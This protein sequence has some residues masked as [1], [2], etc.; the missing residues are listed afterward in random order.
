MAASDRA[1]EPGVHRYFIASMFDELPVGPPPEL[2][3]ADFE[4]ARSAPDLVER[5]RDEDAPEASE[6]WN[7][8]APVP[9]GFRFVSFRRISA[10]RDLPSA[11]GMMKLLLF[12]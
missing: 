1:A 6:F 2:R 5:P 4:L 7:R 12:V 9:A 11:L 10:S 3:P 8:S